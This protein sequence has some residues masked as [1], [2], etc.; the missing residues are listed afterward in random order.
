MK[1]E[2]DGG[3]IQSDL[4]ANTPAVKRLKK[5]FSRYDQ[6]SESSQHRGRW[7]TAG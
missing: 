1:T 3:Q 5:I 7:W 6:Q 2:A 4:Y